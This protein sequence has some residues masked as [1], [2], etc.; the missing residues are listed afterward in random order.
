ML[1]FTGLSL[2][3]SVTPRAQT[4]SRQAAGSRD[5]RMKYWERF[6]LFVI[7]FDNRPANE[8][9]LRPSASQPH[10]LSFRAVINLLPWE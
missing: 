7:R 6:L 3:Y 2:L 9:L 1:Q 4:A 8:L 5:T 10:A